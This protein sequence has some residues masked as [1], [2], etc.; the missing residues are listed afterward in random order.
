LPFGVSAV[1]SIC[2]DA[3]DEARIKVKAGLQPSI[4]RH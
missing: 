4:N 2:A 3:A 1:F